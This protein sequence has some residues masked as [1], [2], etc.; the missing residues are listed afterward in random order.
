VKALQKLHEGAAAIR[1]ERIGTQ[2]YI[3]R[4]DPAEAAKLAELEYWTTRP[5]EWIKRKR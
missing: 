3:R 5:P 4:V 2:L 1:R